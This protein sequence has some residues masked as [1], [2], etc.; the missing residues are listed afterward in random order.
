MSHFPNKIGDCS[1]RMRHCLLSNFVVKFQ[2]KTRPRRVSWGV[3]NSSNFPLKPWF[4]TGVHSKQRSCAIPNECEGQ[5]QI[6]AQLILRS[7]DRMY[8]SNFKLCI[9]SIFS[10]ALKTRVTTLVL[11][12]MWMFVSKS[13]ILAQLSILPQSVHSNWHGIAVLR[14]KKKLCGLRNTLNPDPDLPLPEKD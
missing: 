11:Q 14:I 6:R 13:I 12:R 5:L 9:T 7:A 8:A 4:Q 3:Q 10:K 2:Y 1:K